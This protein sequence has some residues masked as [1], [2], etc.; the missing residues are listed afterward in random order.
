LIPAFGEAVEA[1]RIGPCDASVFL[2]LA[3]LRPHDGCPRTI[4]RE[5]TRTDATEFPMSHDR[6]RLLMRSRRSARREPLKIR[7]FDQGNRNF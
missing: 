1:R 3:S 6:T 5:R 4:D 2:L 7:M